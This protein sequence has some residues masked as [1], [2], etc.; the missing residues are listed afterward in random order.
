ML[1]D[2]NNRPVCL[3]ETFVNVHSSDAAWELIQAG[4]ASRKTASTL[5]NDTSSRSHFICKIIL[6]SDAGSSQILLVD[7]SGSERQA[8][9]IVHSAARMK[10]SIAINTSLMVL[11][12]CIRT[13]ALARTDPNIRI[14]Y[15]N[16]KLT[17]L[18]KDVFFESENGRR[19]E[20]IMVATV[21]P[22]IADVSHTLN[23]FRYACALNPELRKAQTPKRTTPMSWKLQKLQTWFEEA[24]NGLV[25]LGNVCKLQAVSGNGSDFVSPPWKYLYDL[26]VN[27]WSRKFIMLS[28]TESAALRNAYRSLFLAPT[29]S[30][31]CN[32]GL[33][34]SN[35]C[36]SSLQL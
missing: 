31:N 3:G 21:S 29:I 14:P 16:S 35:N 26:S 25:Q 27:D 7:L 18:L 6:E 22:T 4:F 12:E 34:I 17:M 9:S 24:S 33:S 8:D 23:T 19:N 11:K 2:S 20:T 36:N 30:Y 28:K 13:K 5:K 32:R 1:V 10:E 15:R